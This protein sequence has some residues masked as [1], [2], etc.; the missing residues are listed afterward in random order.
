M[1][2]KD[3]QAGG[4]FRGT[5]L[6]TEWKESPFRSKAG[7]FITMT[8][9]DCSAILPAK[10]WETEVSHF[11]WLQECDVF[12]VEASV[13]EFRGTQELTIVK[14]QPV[15]A[16]DIDLNQLLP[17]SPIPAEILEQRLQKLRNSIREQNL[18][19]LL[20]R[21]LD[22]PTI[23]V[24]YRRAPAAQKIHQPYLKGLWEHSLSVAE[25]TISISANYP[26]ANVDLL[27]AGALLHDIGKIFEYNFE[28][29]ISY[30]T[31]GRLLGHIIMGVDLLS[32]E[33]AG[34]PDFPS[35]LRI[36]LLHIITSHHGRYEWQSPRRPK[37][38]EAVIIHY[39]DA[40][41]ADLW[42]FRRA[43][44]GNSREEWSPYIKSLE[45]FVYL[46]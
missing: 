40:L 45:R 16:A 38:L 34:I 8:C 30:T 11:N 24:S 7:T 36:K 42:Q 18:K 5:V 35:D 13:S 19:S 20:D 43:K 28:R 44:E 33:I 32:R 10:I 46:G 23:G 31:D 21:I 27:I 15:T 22:H 41:E 29:G 9:Q 39:A 25:L 17:S 1:L 12:Q 37:C 2:L 26:E 6:V 4:R 14:L 3:C